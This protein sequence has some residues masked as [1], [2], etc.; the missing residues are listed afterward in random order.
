MKK[1]FFCLFFVG[2]FLLADSWRDLNELHK[3]LKEVGL[4]HKQEKEVKKLF[5]E[6]HHDLKEWWHNNE[7]ADA[8]MMQLF[9]KNE[10]DTKEIANKMKTIHDRKIELDLN[11][12]KDLHAILNEE[13]RSKIS[14]DFGEED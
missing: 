14:K 4:S 11:F 6:Y 5:K 1:I 3:D 8:M 9:V 7:K 10:L 13:Q 2:S 12:L